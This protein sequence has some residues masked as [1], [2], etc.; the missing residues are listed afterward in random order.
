MPGPGPHYVLQILR[1][2]R[3]LLILSTAAVA[4]EAGLLLLYPYLSKYQVNVLEGRGG[5]AFAGLRTPAA[6]FLL[7]V[8]LILCANLVTTLLAGLGRPLETLLRER[9]VMDADRLLYEK[10]EQMDAGFLEN[11]K[12]RKLVYSFFDVNVLPVSV[13]EFLRSVV[14]IVIALAGILPILAFVDLKLCLLIAAFSAVQLLILRFRVRRENA[15]RLYKARAMA[16]INELTFLL[17]YYFH[18]VLGAAG[19]ERV[20]PRFWEKRRQVVALELTQ[21]RIGARYEIFDHV[22]ANLSLFAAA[23]LIGYRVLHGG[24]SIGAF[25]MVTLY[26]A[27]LQSSLSAINLNIG[28]WYRLRTIFVQLG[29]FLSMKPRVD[30]S[31]TRSPGQP[32]AGDVAL[33]AVDFHYPGLLD[34]EKAYIGHLVE[35]LSLANRRREASPSDYEL[36]REW[37]ALLEEHREPFPAVLRG[38][39]CRFERGKVNAL[40]GRNGSGK[41]TMM[42]LLVRGYDPDAGRIVVA[43]EPLR[44]LDP[45][46]V[47]RCFSLV[48]QVPFVLDSFSIR[49]NLLLGCAPDVAEDRVWAVL[50]RLDLR[51]VIERSARGLDSLVGD[52]VSL[53]GGESQL[54]VLAR[55]L[56]QRRPFILLDEGTSQLDAEHELRVLELLQ[57]SRQ[58]STVVIITHRMTTARKADKIL[59]LDDGRIVEQGTHEQL[60]ELEQGLYRRF[61]EIQVVS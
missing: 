58:E 9:L 53:S 47:R 30:V 56:L 4:L 7:V 51:R 48:T 15:F 33:E 43:D 24:M 26:T 21:S 44:G 10:L 27:Q 5:L 16:G 32:L 14:K 19:E 8:G 59:A 41:S 42:K 61:W 54:L 36:V 60:V 3:G 13:L 39:S 22:I 20:M 29:F 55:T 40:V 11:P 23:V 28:E 25:V 18:Q 50:E 57:E 38:L 12:N 45:R 35:E 37:K 17:R 6:V 49:D 31:S 1:R 52:E 34:D 46:Y 2:N